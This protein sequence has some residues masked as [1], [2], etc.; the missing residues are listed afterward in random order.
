MPNTI[1]L[2]LFVFDER[3]ACF[4]RSTTET[5]QS[6]PLKCE[7]WMDVPPTHSLAPV[8]LQINT[9]LYQQ[10]QLAEVQ[11]CI[12]YDQAAVSTLID[13]PETLNQLGCKRWQILSW[14]RLFA[15]DRAT[16]S[17]SDSE[18]LSSHALPILDT[19]FDSSLEDRRQARRHA[20]EGEEQVYKDKL[21]DMRQEIIRLQAQIE[22]SQ[23][24]SQEHL[25]AYMPAIFHNFW[26][27]ISPHELAMLAGSLQVPFIPSPHPEP[28]ADTVATLKKRLLRMPDNERR[29]ILSFSR[30]LSHKLKV[31]AQMRD[32]LEACE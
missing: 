24:P 10:S 23:L 14:E 3:A 13:T 1:D 27:S 17:H 9:E 16:A 29:R 21:R 19:L 32:L 12:I 11:L 20:L 4:R 6:L 5:W 8:L 28:S 22:A 15:G 18:W 7:P 2:A 30:D 31:R 25:L 26:G